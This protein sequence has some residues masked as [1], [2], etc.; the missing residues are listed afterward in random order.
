MQKEQ[1]K[2]TFVFNVIDQM[3]RDKSLRKICAESEGVLF[4]LWKVQGC[5]LK[6]LVIP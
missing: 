6:L 4:R 5:L 3:R 1:Q 2:D